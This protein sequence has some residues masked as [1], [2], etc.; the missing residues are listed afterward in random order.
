MNVKI[1]SLIK[2]TGSL[3]KKVERLVYKKN[4]APDIDLLIPDDNYLKLRSRYYSYKNLL[5]KNNELLDTLSA[6]DEEIETKTIT[7]PSLKS[8]LA[9]IFD[10]SFSFIQS[11][12]DMSDNRYVHLFDVLERIKTKT[13]A[14]LQKEY[15]EPVR[16]WVLPVEK[17]TARNTRDTGA[18]A[19]NLGEIR[20]M[21]KMAA[22]RGFSVTIWAYREFMSFNNL[23]Q[24]IEALLTPLNMNDPDGIDLASGKIQELIMNSRVPHLI[25]DQILR[26]ADRIGNDSRFSVRSSAVGEDGRISF[27]GQFK[28]VLNVDRGSLI[29]AYKQV[30]ASK[31]GRRALFY[32][33]AKKV[34][35]KDMPM[36]V[37]VLEMVNS[38]SAGVLYTLNPS[39]PDKDETIISS[40][41]GQ[42]QYAVSGTISPDMFILDR[43]NRGEIVSKT[44][45]SKDMKMIMDP[46]G[47]IKEVSVPVELREVPSISDHEIAML[48][49]FS[50]L[51][52][53]HFETPQDIEWAVDEQGQIWILQT[54]PLHIKRV[55]SRSDSVAMYE[56]RVLLS[57]GETASRGIASGPAYIV[58]RFEQLSSFPDGAVLVARS[59]S[60]EYVKVMESAAALVIETGSKM[61]HL[62]TVAREFNK[63]MIINV[64]KVRE[65]IDSGEVVTVD[66]NT[67][68][69][70]RGR[71][72]SQAFI[73]HEP[74]ASEEYFL[75]EKIVKKAMK[76]IT[77]LNLTTIN[78]ADISLQ[79]F[80]TVH[81]II[82]YVH[83]ISVK[84]MFR[85]G[86]LTE[87]EGSTQ[88]LL[89][90]LVPM[91]FY[92]IDLDGGVV[93]EAKF[94]RK[95]RPEHIVSIPFNALWRGMTHEGVRWSGAVDIDVGGLASV[96]A[97][98]FVRTGV[99]EKGG[100]VYVII[101]DQYVNLSVKLAYHFSIIDA[102]CG[103]SYINN[104][105][106]FRFQGGGA[107]AEGRSRRAMFI[108]E[109][110]EAYNFRVEVKGD[111]VI[112]DLKG[113]SRKETEEKLDILGRL[114]G[115]S[116]QL[117]MAI[118]SIDAKDW[119]V[120]AFLEGN[121]SFAHE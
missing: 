38:R 101:T 34:K 36:A 28:S 96:M 35:D 53:K 5:L 39:S 12:N 6:V 118:S 65:I 87:G 52:E 17:I 71:S 51:I 22:P 113:A 120:K 69:I 14:E 84:E 13:E 62:A 72:D 74:E 10:T 88:L 45:P 61:S 3:L 95:I 25:E 41:W 83:E 42:G 108:K 81:D 11:L 63:P 31:Y 85:I 55:I 119:Y 66:A 30:L 79:D 103:E 86:E 54:R 105:I 48:Y 37:F 90:E 56:K 94:L 104:Y 29:D 116:R 40:V 21:L 64:K 20:N 59:S 23:N 15:E 75:I 112:A 78:E 4:N 26:E 43:K 99:T 115:C 32:R 50:C 76:N 49:D 80:Q 19:G 117:D 110:M 70:Y 97:R 8:F 24:R 107:A 33:L 60:N 100:K 46:S 106:N 111:L 44:I 82:R 27:A 16:D 2:K 92:V 68:R 77:P 91:Y 58:D 73:K 102:F 89:S 121:Y 109:I 67:G 98:S 114:M 57:E 9:R 93:D 18:K 47:G 1:N 7:L